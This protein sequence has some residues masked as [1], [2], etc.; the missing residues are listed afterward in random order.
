M[1]ESQLSRVRIAVGALE[2]GQWIYHASR[3]V[4]NLSDRFAVFSEALKRIRGTRP[5]Y[6]EFGVYRGRTLRWW[7]E[8]LALPTALFV[9][10]DSFQGLPED[11]RADAPKGWFTPDGLPRFDDPRVSLVPG[12]FAETLP[13]WTPP[14]HDQLIINIDCDLYSSARCVLSHL[15]AYC[16]EGTLVYFDDLLDCDDELRALREWLAIRGSSVVPV[17]MARWG[18]HMLFECRA[19]RG[20]VGDDDRPLR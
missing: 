12:W 11:W 20:P 6:L 2:E 18:Q 8:H 7:S 5:L 16:G 13:T 10:F 15:D 3:P 1:S 19:H 9:G 17:A 4:R 14:D